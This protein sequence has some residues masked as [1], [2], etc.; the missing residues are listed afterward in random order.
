MPSMGLIASTGRLGAR[1]ASRLEWGACVQ[2]TG[3]S[4]FIWRDPSGCGSYTQATTPPGSC[5]CP[6]S[7]CPMRLRMHIRPRW[8]P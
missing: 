3:R 2:R 4:V 8:R 6:R 7:S 5:P 1:L